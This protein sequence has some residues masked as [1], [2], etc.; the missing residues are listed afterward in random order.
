MNS[1]TIHSKP[2][3]GKGTLRKQSSNHAQWTQLQ[4]GGIR[5]IGLL[6]IAALL[7][8]GLLVD[9]YWQGNRFAGMEPHPFLLAAI[10]AAAHYGL[11]EGLIGALA[12]GLALRVHNLP[13][14][15][16]DTDGYDYVWACISQPLGWIALAVLVGALRNHHKGRQRRSEEQLSDSLRRERDISAGF[17]HVRRAKNRLEEAVA[18]HLRSAVTL[19]KAA[20]H[21]ERLDPLDVI[22]GAGGLVKAGLDPEKFSLYLLDGS[23]LVCVL[24]HG[25]SRDEGVW[26]YEESSPLFQRTVGQRTTTC[27]AR[28]GEAEALGGDGIIAGPLVAEQTGEVVGML[29]IEQIGFLSLNLAA[30]QN[31]EVLCRWLGTALVKAQEHADGHVSAFFNAS[32][33]IVSHAMFEQQSLFLTRVARRLNFELSTLSVR[34]ECAERLPGAER[35]LIAQALGSSVRSVLRATDLAFEAERIGSGY[36]ILLPNTSEAGAKVVENKL[37]AALQQRQ[38]DAGGRVRLTFRIESLHA[39]RAAKSNS[40]GAVLAGVS[41]LQETLSHADHPERHSRREVPLG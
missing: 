5:V 36:T 10:L 8:A 32:T 33:Q 34:L 31:F 14:Q 40:D 25:H 26:A 18:G 19:Y 35:S 13:P 38:A 29:K 30:V 37:K 15:L 39:A 9:R 27:V 24:R 11:G 16:A 3:P 21:V 23:S 22:G 41:R 6:E 1:T 2:S 4:V 20:Q 17:D 12:A 7:T 28:P